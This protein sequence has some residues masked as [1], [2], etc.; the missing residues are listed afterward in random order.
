MTKEWD[1]LPLLQEE[2]RSLLLI[3]HGHRDPFPPHSLGTDIS[4]T[5]EGVEAS[6]ALGRRLRKV[7]LQSLYTSPV[8]RC[9]QTAEAIVQGL[10]TPLEITTSSLLG[11]PGPFIQDANKSSPLFLKLPFHQIAQLIVEGNTLPGMRSLEEGVHL[12][13]EMVLNVSQ[14]P[15]L[16]ISH[17]IIIALL[18]TFL[19]K[20]TDLI[21]PIP[22]FL[23]GMILQL[24][25]DRFVLYV[26]GHRQYIF[27]DDVLI[28]KL[29]L[30]TLPSI[31][32]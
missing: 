7:K 28:K 3:R 4:L 8:K 27:Y 19:T 10:A 2:T 17:D 31:V 12:F 14:F 15:C 30:Q 5:E 29:Q 18:I 13:L 16:M 24:E 1:F 20:S 26:N 23:E 25:Q 9:Q 11:D 22:D 21:S 32:M 6:T